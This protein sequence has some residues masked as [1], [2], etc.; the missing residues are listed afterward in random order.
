MDASAIHAQ[1]VTIVDDIF[2]YASQQDD[3]SVENALRRLRRNGFGSDAFLTNRLALDA[4][5]ALVSVLDT[6]R[7]GSRC[8]ECGTVEPCRTLRVL[9]EVFLPVKDGDP[10]FDN[11]HAEPASGSPA[12][13]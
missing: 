10:V 11:P 3:Q 5:T 4:S 1:L 6:H 9:S 7:Y 8:A 12:Q 2:E 13:Q